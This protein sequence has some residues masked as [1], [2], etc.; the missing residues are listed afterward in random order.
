M[1]E[2]LLQHQQGKENNNANIDSIRKEEYYNINKFNTLR[3]SIWE[4]LV[5]IL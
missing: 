3:E 2:R 1:N 5:I 4:T